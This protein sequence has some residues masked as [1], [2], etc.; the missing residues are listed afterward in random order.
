MHD[1]KLTPGR[2]GGAS[3]QNMPIRATAKTIILPPQKIPRIFTVDSQD[4]TTGFA[5]PENHALWVSTPLAHLILT[6]SNPGDTD[7][8]LN[9]PPDVYRIIPITQILGVGVR[10]TQETAE[11][12]SLWIEDLRAMEPWICHGEFRPGG[13]P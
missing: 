3:A 2:G 12:V 11:D 7:I 10:T 5:I 9:L 8:V 13:A 4:Q 6:L 1:P